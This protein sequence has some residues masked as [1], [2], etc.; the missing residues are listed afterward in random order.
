MKSLSVF[1]LVLTATLFHPVSAS[2]PLSTV[3]TGQWRDNYLAKWQSGDKADQQDA[4]QQLSALLVLLPPSDPVA[5]AV[6]D[7]LDVQQSADAQMALAFH[8]LKTG[9]GRNASQRFLDL[10]L[11]YPG[12]PRINRFRIALA[13]AFR[14]DRQYDLAAAQ[15]EPL[16]NLN[17]TDG[18]WA[19]LE[20][21]YLLRETGNIE[22][23][24]TVLKMLTPAVRGTGYLEK[25]VQETLAAA[26]TERMLLLRTDTE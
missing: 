6:G 17:T 16:M 25:L 7:R 2:F 19:M 21:A 18:K 5:N 10:I 8:A 1:F 23:A 14:L 11:Q 26:G 15:L 3:T 13:R 20:K 24:V 12:D 22:G 9:S 4:V